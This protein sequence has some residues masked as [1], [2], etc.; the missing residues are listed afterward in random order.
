MS[1]NATSW[2]PQPTLAGNG[3]LEEHSQM[4]SFVGGMLSQLMSYSTVHELSRSSAAETQV[5]PI[6]AQ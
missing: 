5:R 1:G 4:A 6:V 2:P 3:V